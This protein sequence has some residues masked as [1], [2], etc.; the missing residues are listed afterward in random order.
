MPYFTT[1]TVKLTVHRLKPHAVFNYFIQHI[2]APY[3]HGSLRSL[4]QLKVINENTD[5]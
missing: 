4:R 1:I 3:L 5:S 2:S